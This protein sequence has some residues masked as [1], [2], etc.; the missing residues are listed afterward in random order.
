MLSAPA[1]KTCPLAT[2]S[3]MIETDFRVGSIDSIS[4]T[5]PS[6]RH[7]T[8]S[9]RPRPSLALST[10]TPGS[11]SQPAVFNASASV[12]G[13]SGTGTSAETSSMSLLISPPGF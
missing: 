12:F 8:I 6:T 7:R 2:S 5:R 3:A 9:F 10:Q 4:S 1:W 13:F 11:L